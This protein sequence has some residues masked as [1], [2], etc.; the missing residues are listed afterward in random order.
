[1]IVDTSALIAIVFRESG[2]EGLIDLLREKGPSGIAAPSL[3][4]A[5][6]VASAR[7]KRDAWP[8]LRAL[9]TELDISVVP[10][11]DD[12]ARTAVAAWMRFGKGRHPAALNFGDCISYAVSKLAKMPLLCIGTDFRRT[13]LDLA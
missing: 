7:L 6:I 11:G 5:G 10:F 3:V 4:E 9:M 13:D 8:V 2:Y 12:H 1:M